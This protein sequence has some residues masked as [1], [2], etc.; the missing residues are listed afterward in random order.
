MLKQH[1]GIALHIFSFRV[2]PWTSYSALEWQ[3]FILC[4]GA[5]LRVHGIVHAIDDRFDG[6]CRT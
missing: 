6:T 2:L 5:D 1:E 3:M 4:V